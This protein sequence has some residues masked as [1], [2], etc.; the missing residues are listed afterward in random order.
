MA[1]RKSKFIGFLLAI[2]TGP[3]SFLYV[4]KRKKALLCFALL[5]VPFVNVVVYLFTLFGIVSDVKEYNKD[6][7][8]SA[9]FGFVVCQCQSLNRPGCKFCSNCGAK[10]VKACDE[11]SGTVGINEK[12]C[13]NC[14]NAFSRFSALKFS[15][16]KMVPF[17]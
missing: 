16:R 3:L 6:V 8:G 15:M 12:Y 7:N 17:I 9:R 14:G 2:F 1:K 11:C 10:L 5:F 13:R 4:R